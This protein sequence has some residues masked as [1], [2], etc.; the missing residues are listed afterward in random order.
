MAKKI[1]YS[2]LGLKV[3]NA[4]PTIVTVGETDIEIL[5]YLPMED[6][7]AL[8]SWVVDNA[9]DDTTGRFSPIRLDTYFYIAIAKWYGNITFTD[10]Q[11]ENPAKIYDTLVTND[12]V[13]N[14]LG[15]IPEEEYDYLEELLENTVE[16]IADYNSSFAGIVRSMSNKTDDLGGQVNDILEALKNREG[17]ELLSEIKNI[18]G[19]ESN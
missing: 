16:D 1:T 19:T 9:I 13:L 15:G 10:K 18:T 6:K 17:I 12:V 4:E 2:K 14:I 3:K 8:I 5:Q 11:M 7:A